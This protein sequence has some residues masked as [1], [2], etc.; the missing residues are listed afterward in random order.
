M[1]RARRLLA[2]ASLAALASLATAAR[3]AAQIRPVPV[4]LDRGDR[5][6]ALS[7]NPAEDG[8]FD[9]AMWRARLAGAHATTLVVYWDEVEVAP[10]VYDAGWLP[11]ANA[12]FPAWGMSVTLVVNPIDTTVLR[13]PADLQGLPFDH[14]LVVSR[15]ED[16]LGFVLAQI[17][18]LDLVALSIGNEVDA[19]LGGDP[20]LW[21]AWY[22]FY[23]LTSTR[24][25]SLRPGLVVGCK[26]THAGLTG[27]RWAEL[28]LVNLWSDAVLATYY[29][30]NP[31]FTVQSPAVVGPDLDLLVA[32]YPGRRV[33]L[34]EA[35]YPTSPWCGSSD[36]AQALLVQQVFRAWDRH[37]DVL[38]YVEF[39][40][41]HDVSPETVN[42]WMDYYGFHDLRF[43]E[44]L[45]T[46]G[47]RTY[48]GSGADKW[49]Y[50]MLWWEAHTRGW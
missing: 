49:G 17:P 43:G 35:G 28:Q 30:L 2:T 21:G 27:A 29:P 4:A 23:A 15:F 40:F 16:F 9:A 3:P 44:F 38:K 32:L 48:P 18:A 46:L 19:Y 11:F 10:G 24:A 33:H 7:V 20:A 31:D 25:R 50:A 12:Y 41:L 37:A 45:R 13:V 42:A 14:P 26:A 8:D 39:T 6:L 36:L 1:K 34:C 5:V 47:L 22:G